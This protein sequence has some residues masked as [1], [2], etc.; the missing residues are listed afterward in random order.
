MD[1]PFPPQALMA[2]IVVIPKP[3]KDTTFCQNCRPISLTNID[4]Q[5][6]SKFLAN[7]LS[8]HFPN[9]IHLDR[10]GFTTMRETH[11]NTIKTI[12]LIN[13]AQSSKTPMCLLSVDAEKAFDR[14][15]WLFLEETLHQIDLGSPFL[16]KILAL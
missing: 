11:N 12:T 3:G 13:H 5:M 10:V 1:T 16:Q 14:V 4:L 6:Y 7:R 15:K 8:P 9:F 2:Y